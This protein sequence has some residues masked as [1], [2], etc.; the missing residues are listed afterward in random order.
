[1]SLSPFQFN[2]PK[3][4]ELSFIINQNFVRDSSAPLPLSLHF[5]RNIIK[6]DGENTAIVELTLHMNVDRNDVKDESAPY[7][8]NV[9]YGAQF[10]WES[11]VSEEAAQ[12]FLNVN[13]PTLLLSYIR[14]IVA[15]MTAASPFPEYHLP[16]INMVELFEVENKGN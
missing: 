9:K 5:N 3:L 1:M 10:I 13:A 16:F 6:N 11:I 8:L 4:T 14:P 15:Q 7:W 2:T 12:R